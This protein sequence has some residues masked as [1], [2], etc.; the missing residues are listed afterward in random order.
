M[1]TILNSLSDDGPSGI[2]VPDSIPPK[3]FG[4]RRVEEFVGHGST[5]Q[6]SILDAGTPPSQ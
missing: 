4:L 6:F 2:S 3:E 5:L 1:R